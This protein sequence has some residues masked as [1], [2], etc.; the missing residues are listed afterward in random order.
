MY[1][2]TSK[3]ERNTNGQSLVES[4]R[5]HEFDLRLHTVQQNCEALLLWLTVLYWRGQ[6]SACQL[7]CVRRLVLPHTVQR[8]I[9]QAIFLP[10]LFQ[11]RHFYSKESKSKDSSTPKTDRQ[12][13]Q[14]HES[15]RRRRQT[16]ACDGVY[17]Q[18]SQQ[19][20]KH[21]NICS[22]TRSNQDFK[23]LWHKALVLEGKSLERYSRIAVLRR[24]FRRFYFFKLSIE[25]RNNDRFASDKCWKVIHE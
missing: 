24:R 4:F 5:R 17:R 20:P 13:L 7:V 11:S 25:Q 1:L 3:H 12:T 15:I 18:Q 14:Q 10:V 16:V 23:H 21:N 9:L 6:S 19:H 8:T 2:V 22:D